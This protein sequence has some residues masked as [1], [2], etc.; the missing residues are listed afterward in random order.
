[1]LHRIVAAKAHPNYRL[2]VRFADGKEGEVDLSALVGK[3][4]L[5]AT[6]GGTLG[7][8][9]LNLREPRRRTCRHRILALLRSW[10]QGLLG[11][12][13]FL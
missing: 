9:V 7:H 5:H 2:W 12:F 8:H 3:G 11:V 10:L 6:T 1:M 4:Y 13:S